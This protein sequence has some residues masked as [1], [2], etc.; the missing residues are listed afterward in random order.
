MENAQI[1]NIFD[2]IADLLDLK[3]ANTFRVR[4][5]RDAARTIRGLPDRLEDLAGEDKEFSDLSNI[6]E[7]TAKKIHEIL[8][9]GTC[10]RLEDLK[11]ELPESLTR[12]MQVPGL[13]ARKA[14]TL[15]EELGVDDLDDLKQACEDHK[16][17]DIEGFGEKTEQ[18][19]LEGIETL[20]S[21][22]DRILYKDA[23]DHVT[24]LRQFLDGI[25]AIG[26]WDV[27]GSYRR[28]KETIGDLDVVIRAK[29]RHAAG[30]AILDY[31]EIRNVDSKGKEKITVHLKS[32]LQIDFR[33]FEQHDY[34]SAMLYFTGSKAHNIKLRR[35]A[36]GHDWKLNEYGLTKG[37]RR[38]AGKDEESIYHRLGLTWTPPE[39]REDRGEIDIADEDALPTL[40]APKEIR[41]D[42]QSHTDASDGE[43]SIR[44]MAE[45]AR[46]QGYNFFAITD[47]S[48]RVTMANGLDD[49][50]CRKHAEE[51]RTVNEDYHNLW[52]MAG[53]E[54][55]ILKDGS[56]DLSED[57]LADLDW[58]MAS[59]HYDR[60]LGETKM[61]E[62]Y[63]SAI[64]SGVVHAV[65]HPLGRLIGKRDPL[66]IDFG[67]IIETCREHDVFLEINAQP[68]RLDLPDTYIQQARDAGVL[69]T[70]GTDAHK[71][72]ELEFMRFGVNNARRGWLE[73]GHLLNTLTATKLRKRIKRN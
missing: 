37:D 57:V 68:D 24:S 36:Q 8:D 40:V 33:F 19:I 3:Q 1:A 50:R 66:P 10:R 70:L 9:R 22:G 25:D 12:V 18:K 11:K 26:Q 35:I 46:A 63:C 69:F 56:L 14:M 34:G 67:K 17:R 6:G 28:C 43:G 27:A 65:A 4:S 2:E 54:V 59:I 51:I 55:D 72:A 44:D 64:R 20:A 48:K 16:V 32:G 38:L 71:P 61:T 62:R 5:Y 23:D 31:P 49:D 29:D 52:L 13:G 47:H 53:V 21:T 60:T 30:E 45:A 39:L 7:K 15:H 42:L 58:V 41:G 73:S